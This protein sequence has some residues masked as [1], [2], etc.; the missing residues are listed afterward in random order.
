MFKNSPSH[1]AAVCQAL[2]VTFLW[3]LS[4]VLIKIGLHDV[5]ALTFAGLR[6]TLAFLFLLPLFLRFGGLTVLK[7]LNRRDWAALIT[8]GLVYYA[9]TQGA[10]F[11]G[12]A[13]L[14]AVTVSLLLNLSAPVVALLG[15]FWLGERPTGGQWAGMALCLGGIGI[16]FNGALPSG[17]Q[18]TGLVI[19]L[20]GLLANAASSILGRGLNRQQR[21]SPLTITTSSMGIGGFSLLTAGLTTQPLPSFTPASWLIV[22]W[23]ALVNTALAFTL[24]NNALRTLSAMESSLL[25]NTMLAQIALLAWIFLGEG[26]TGVQIL[27]LALVGLGALV[28]Q[29]RVKLGFLGAKTGRENLA[30]QTENPGAIMETA[31]AARKAE[32]LEGELD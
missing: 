7:G 15:L 14:P 13:F 30:G 28:V 2:F 22:G 17:A 32:R 8:L 20:V 31:K 9:L 6:Y 27:G 19:M 11:L 24:W 10:Q 3:S 18:L 5:P 21:F 29:L 4:W 12:L 16:Y 25:N 23:L 1:L 26:V